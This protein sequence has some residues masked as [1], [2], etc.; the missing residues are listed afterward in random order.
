MAD[1][2]DEILTLA[3]LYLEASEVEHLVIWLAHRKA[4]NQ[5]LAGNR[6]EMD[7]LDHVVRH[8]LT[9]PEREQLVRWMLERASRREGLIPE[10]PVGRPER[11]KG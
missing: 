8:W 7:R 11:R 5:A 2:C 6:P 4:K 1:T 9:E 10:R 3:R